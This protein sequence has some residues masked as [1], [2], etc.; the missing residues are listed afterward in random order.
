MNVKVFGSNDKENRH[1]HI[2]FSNT[3]QI[4]E[5]KEKDKKIKKMG[6]EIRGR[7]KIGTKSKVDV[8]KQGGRIPNNVAKSSVALK[9]SFK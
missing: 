6:E 7:M 8:V 1:N 5:R 9:P 4:I 2:N 3:S